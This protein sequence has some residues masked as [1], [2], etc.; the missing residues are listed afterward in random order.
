MDYDKVVETLK[1]VQNQL[2]L[3]YKKKDDRKEDKKT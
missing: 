1:T 2:N 3:L